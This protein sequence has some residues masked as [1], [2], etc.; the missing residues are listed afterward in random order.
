MK[1]QDCYN[2]PYNKAQR[3]R[4]AMT[5]HIGGTKTQGNYGYDSPHNKAQRQRT[6]MT[7]HITTYEDRGLI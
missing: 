4:V 5:H 7:H 2:S 6:A 1:T 3:H